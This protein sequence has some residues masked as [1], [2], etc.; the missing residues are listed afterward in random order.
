MDNQK[1]FRVILEQYCEKIEDAHRDGGKF[2]FKF[3]IFNLV[4][5]CVEMNMWSY[6]ADQGNEILF[7]TPD[8][9]QSFFESL[10]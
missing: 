9:L 2:Y 4:N 1:A 10:T 3:L 6:D 7:K 8:K 5:N